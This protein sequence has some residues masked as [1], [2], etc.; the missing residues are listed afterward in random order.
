MRSS[1]L[2]T[3]GLYT[4]LL[5]F[6]ALRYSRIIYLPIFGSIG[7]LPIS[8][9]TRCRIVTSGTGIKVNSPTTYQHIYHRETKNLQYRL[10]CKTCFVESRMC[11]SQEAGMRD[12]TAGIHLCI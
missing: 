11:S 9:S 1:L 6:E 3:P 8:F 4:G 10:D 5:K 12:A 2:E 7:R